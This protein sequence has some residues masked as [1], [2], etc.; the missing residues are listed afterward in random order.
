[1]QP[2]IFNANELS[3]SLPLREDLLQT[4][5]WLQ[6]LLQD[7]EI[8]DIGSFREH[9]LHMLRGPAVIRGQPL[10]LLF[11]HKGRGDRHRISALRVDGHIKPDAMN[12]LRFIIRRNGRTLTP[13]LTVHRR[14]FTSQPESLRIR[15]RS[16]SAGR[17]G[18]GTPTASHDL[19]GHAGERHFVEAVRARFPGLD[20]SWAN[21]HAE[22]GQPYD[23]LIGERLAVDVKA[24]RM[25]RP[26][27][28]LSEAELGFRDRYPQHHTIALVTLR[29]DPRQAPLSIDLYTGMQG[30]RVPFIDLPDLFTGLR[31]L[32]ESVA[33]SETASGAPTCR[34]VTTDSPYFRPGRYESGGGEEAWVFGAAGRF[35]HGGECGAYRLQG[36]DLLAEFG[37]SG[38]GTRVLRLQTTPTAWILTEEHGACWTLV[39]AQGAINADTPEPAASVRE[40]ADDA[41]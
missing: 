39:K 15:K 33:Q 34:M 38:G 8:H 1:M 25:E 9:G 13:A 6:A 24:T 32:P 21:E 40:G 16:S 14:G 29:D 35:V 22:S 41:Q 19:F 23:V 3:S 11:E 31:P 10:T 36:H 17:A 18:T 28:D 20:V 30:R 27:V 4:T 12:L 5:R 26:Y 2:Q 7:E 37:P